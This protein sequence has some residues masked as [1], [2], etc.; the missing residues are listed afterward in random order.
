MNGHFIKHIGINYL[1][2]YFFSAPLRKV[3][4]VGRQGSKRARRTSSEKKEKKIKLKHK[5]KGIV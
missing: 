2:L 3:F 1:M 5:I 4:G